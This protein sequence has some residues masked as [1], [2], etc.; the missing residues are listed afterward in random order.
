[1]SNIVRSSTEDNQIVHAEVAHDEATIL[2][3]RPWR[4]ALHDYLEVGW[5]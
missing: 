3:A 5:P 4:D 1:M 2:P